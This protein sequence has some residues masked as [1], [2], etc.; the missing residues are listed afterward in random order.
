MA[1]ASE[2]F[3]VR[4]RYWLVSGGMMTRIACGMTTSRR[5]LVGDSPSAEAASV[6][7][8]LMA[9][10]PERTISAMKAAV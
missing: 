1:V 2:E 3:L 6:C 5:V 9:W 4:F 7:P 10:M 8:L